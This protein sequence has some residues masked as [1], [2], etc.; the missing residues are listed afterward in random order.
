MKY[1]HI[2]G[3][4]VVWLTCLHSRHWYAWPASTNS[5]HRWSDLAS[6]HPYQFQLDFCCGVCLREL[7]SAV[8]AHMLDYGWFCCFH[9]SQIFLIF[10]SELHALTNPK[11]LPASVNISYLT[12]WHLTLG[13]EGH[14]TVRKGHTSWLYLCVNA[15]ER[16]AVNWWE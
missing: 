2:L 10:L 6:G 12:D 5:F 15:Y 13:V 7:F 8:F 4:N 9:T 3:V 11:E 14:R 1:V 16:E